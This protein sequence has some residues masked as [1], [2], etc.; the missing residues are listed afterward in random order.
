ML[1]NDQLSSEIASL[2]DS[3]QEEVEHF[4]AFLKTRV[5]PPQPPQPP[6]AKRQFGAA[7][8]FFKMSDDFEE[9]LEDFKE[10]M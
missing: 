3:L 6:L 5:Q 1:T 8:G 7:K 10:Y 9:P 2:P 4:V